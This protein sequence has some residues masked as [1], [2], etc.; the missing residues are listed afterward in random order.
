MVLNRIASSRPVRWVQ[1][2]VAAA[3]QTLVG[4]TAERLGSAKPRV[5]ASAVA[6]NLFFAAVPLFLA[7]IALASLVGR[8]EAALTE[9]EKLLADA[10]PGQIATFITD[11]LEG[12]QSTLGDA[13]I[14]TAVISLVVALWSGSRATVTIVEALDE[15]EGIDD[16]RPWIQIRA[17]GYAGSAGL[18]LTLVAMVL[19]LVLGD[20]IVDFLRRL[21]I[22]GAA[23]VV[24][25]AAEPLAGLLLLVFLYALFR[26]GPPEPLPGT[27]TATLVSAVGIVLASLGFGLATQFDVFGESA[28]FAVLG[29]VALVLL[30]LYVIAYV[31]ITAASFS[32]TLASREDAS[33]V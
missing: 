21:D 8:D 30:W 22:D 1:R 14:T 3:T 19:T 31:L 24:E 13:T 29:G 18:V 2:T 23:N 7:F 6:Y 32:V 20:A 10:L 16:D 33:R 17:I 4:R 27:L 15:I 25:V 11:L 28:T 5:L 9:L 26:W 12:V